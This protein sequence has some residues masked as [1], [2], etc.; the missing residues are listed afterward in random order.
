MGSSIGL[1]RRVMKFCC[2]YPRNAGFRLGVLW[3]E[4][5]ALSWVRVSVV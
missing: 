4:G 3:V 2:Q 5:S 1:S